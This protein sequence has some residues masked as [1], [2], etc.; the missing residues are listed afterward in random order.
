MPRVTVV[1]SG[2]S[3]AATPY[4]TRAA[5]VPSGAK[6][7]TFSRM[8]VA[9]GSAGVSLLTSATLAVAGIGL[10]SGTV[11]SSI[12]WVSGT[13]AANTPLNQ[14]FALYDK[15]LVQLATTTDDT[16]TAW[17]ASSAK[18]LNIATV[19]SGAASTYTIPSTDLYYV[20]IMVKATTP[21]TLMG[22][23]S[24]NAP[25]TGIAPIVSGNSDTSQT[26]PPAFPHTATSLT[27]R[28][29]IPYAYVS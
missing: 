3:A 23:L 2:S 8:D 17:A 14:W 21:P 11:V 12:T 19:A 5:A 4:N 9:L 28:A 26:T 10:A 29:N 24:N 1:T 16:T 7:E 18:T 13:T 25:I 6:G 27:A 22:F 15:N 20:G